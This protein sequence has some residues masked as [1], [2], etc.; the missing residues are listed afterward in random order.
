MVSSNTADLLYSTELFK[1]KEK[2]KTPEWQVLENNLKIAEHCIKIQG[3]ATYSNDKL[4]TLMAQ[5]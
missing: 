4:F 2:K 5:E 1:T 3:F